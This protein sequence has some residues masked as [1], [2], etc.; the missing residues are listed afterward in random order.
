MVLLRYVSH[1]VRLVVHTSWIRKYYLCIGILSTPTSEIFYIQTKV[2]VIICG[3]EEQRAYVPR[4]A[5]RWSSPTVPNV[6][7]RSLAV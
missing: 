7:T 2:L 4:M 1:P 5:D 6:G 3:L